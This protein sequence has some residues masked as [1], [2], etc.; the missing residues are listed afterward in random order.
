MNMNNKVTNVPAI[1]NTY[2]DV[3]GPISADSGLSRFI[4]EG[5]FNTNNSNTPINSIIPKPIIYANSFLY[6]G[7]NSL[8]VKIIKQIQ[9]ETE[10]CNND[11]IPT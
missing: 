6:S 10:W 7:V 5:Y 11:V 4:A 8:F 9:I 1:N 2:H 3:I